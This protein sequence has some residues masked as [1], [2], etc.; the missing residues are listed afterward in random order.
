MTNSSP[1][2]TARFSSGLQD[3]HFLNKKRII[4]PTC[5]PIPLIFT[6]PFFF[7]FC[8]I[9]LNIPSTHIADYSCECPQPSSHVDVREHTQEHKAHTFAI[10]S[11]LVQQSGLDLADS[12][13]RHYEH[14]VLYPRQHVSM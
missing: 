7:F 6:A 12:D 8:S 1:L 13:S 10:G 14:W 3:I 5:S 4:H 2:F 9:H 11:L